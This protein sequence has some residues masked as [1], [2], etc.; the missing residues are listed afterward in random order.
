MKCVQLIDQNGKYVGIVKMKGNKLVIKTP[1]PIKINKENQLEKILTNIQENYFR[2]VA[3]INSNF[4]KVA[5]INSNFPKVAEINDELP[6]VIEDTIT[7][8]YD[9]YVNMEDTSELP[10]MD[11]V[12]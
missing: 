1:L 10:L 4:P 2:E 12:D 7:K 11:E 3:E 6:K 5:E 9:L 8:F